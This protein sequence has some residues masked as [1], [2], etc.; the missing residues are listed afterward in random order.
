MRQFSLP[1][2]VGIPLDRDFVNRLPPGADS[3]GELGEY[4]SFV[5]DGP[6]FHHPIAFTLTPVRR[7]EREIRTTEG[8]RSYAYRLATPEKPP[9]G[10]QPTNMQNG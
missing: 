1:G 2:D 6:L 7:L 8:L 3:C 10:A 5:Y 9:T 4:R